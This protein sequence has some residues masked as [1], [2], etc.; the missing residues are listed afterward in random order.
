MA[1]VRRKCF[2]SHHHADALAV[3]RFIR[4]FGPSRFIK[5]GVTMPEDVI[6]SDNVDYVMRRVRELYI[7]DSTV[8]IVLV[9]K[10]TWARRFVDWEVQASLRRPENALPS[11]LLAILLDSTKRPRLP[12]RVALNRDSGYAKYHYY[13]G[14]GDVLGDWIEDAYNARSRRARLINNPRQRYKYNRP[15][16]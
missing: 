15:C 14:N 4:R 5:R 13:P 10:C 1:G 7:R 11:G 12:N 9:G 6:D 2:I 3:D 16:T 8:T